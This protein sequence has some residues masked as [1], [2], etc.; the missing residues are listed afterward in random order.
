MDIEK[1]IP[2]RQA[3]IMVDGIAEHSDSYLISKFHIKDSNI[4]VED[5]KFQEYGIIENMAQTA[6]L[7]SGYKAVNSGETPK[8]GFIGAVKNFK[9]YDLPNVGDNILSKLTIK[10]EVLNA[11]IVNVES[12]VKNKKIAEA[13]LKIFLIDS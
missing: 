10:T 4:F 3:M 2:Q 6:A 7:S 5:N 11:T 12:F 1:Y 8:T 13:E 9:L